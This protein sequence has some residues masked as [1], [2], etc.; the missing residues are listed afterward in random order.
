MG[1]NYNKL[2]AD[3]DK[4]IQNRTE[5]ATI[6]F[7]VYT[8]D[9]LAKRDLRKLIEVI[10]RNFEELGDIR[11]LKHNRF[12]IADVL[13]SKGSVTIIGVM[14]GVIVCYLIAKPTVYPD[15]RRELFHIYYLFTSPAHR[16]NGAGT[17]MLNMIHKIALE[18]DI[19]TLSLTYDTYNKTLTKYYLQNG[20][21][22]D[23]EIRSY[24]RYD[25][26]VKYL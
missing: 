15:S 20:F 2:M 11:G 24:K 3:R 17:Y 26:L 8:G 5:G 13:T 25:M 1:S 18:N 4:F 19:Y 9:V 14:N 10:Y 21:E 16:G 23:D 6:N 12:E 22:Y 7:L